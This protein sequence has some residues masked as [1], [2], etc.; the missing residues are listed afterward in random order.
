MA[1]RT[2]LGAIMGTVAPM[3]CIQEEGGTD[4][5]TGHSPLEGGSGLCCHAAFILSVPSARSLSLAVSEARTQPAEPHLNVTFLTKIR[6]E[7]QASWI[8]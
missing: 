2:G 1:E 6:G 5:K 7:L 8:M 3:C 4:G